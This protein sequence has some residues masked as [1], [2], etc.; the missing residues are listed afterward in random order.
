VTSTLLLRFFYPF[1]DDELVTNSL[2]IDENNGIYVAS[3]TLMRK[4]VW[5]GTTLSDKSVDGAWSCPY[6]H[7]VVPPGGKRGNGTGTTPALMGFGN[8]PDKL[9]VITD[10][11]K[12]IEPCC[13]LA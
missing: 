2:S 11:A 3:N 5:T 6:T 7:S 10:G 12:Q 4:L 1:G 13:I 8:D 9:V